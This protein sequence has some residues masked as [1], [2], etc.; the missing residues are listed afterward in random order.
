MVLA[1]PYKEQRTQR[2]KMAPRAMEARVIGYTNTRNVY[3]T[4][5]ETGKR[6]LSKET[7]T[8]ALDH[9]DEEEVTSQGY[10]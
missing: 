8:M 3:Q 4:I 2:D 10:T 1:Y 6:M 7:R 9:S 5:M